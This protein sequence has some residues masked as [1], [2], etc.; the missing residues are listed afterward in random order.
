[1]PLRFVVTPDVRCVHFELF[2]EGKLDPKFI[3]VGAKLVTPPSA[4]FLLCTK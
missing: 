2:Y 4:T 1:M 3:K